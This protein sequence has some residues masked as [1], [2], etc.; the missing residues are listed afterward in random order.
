MFGSYYWW[1]GGSF[2]K[3]DENLSILDILKCGEIDSQLAGLL[4]LLM[5]HRASL[6]VA[7]GPSWAGKTTLFHSLLDFLPPKI[8]RVSLRGYEEDFK[9]LGTDKPENTYLVTEEISNHSYEYLWGYQVAK[10]FEFLPKGYALGA[11]IHASNIREVAY[12]LRA[13][14]VSLSLIASLGV[15]ITLQVNPGRS[16][17]DDLVR[18]VDTVSTVNLTKNGLVAHVLATRRSPKEKFTY[19]PEQSLCDILFNKFTVKNSS[20]YSEMELRGDY[21][22]QLRNKGISSRKDVRKE[23]KEYYL[24]RFS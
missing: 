14:G 9:E 20:V 2:Y 12:I 16:Y 17:H 7:A 10:A 8:T 22:N 1:A 24:S 6:V 11:T 23:I 4:W 3:T 5:E 21:L 13:L 18:Y 19:L 15:I